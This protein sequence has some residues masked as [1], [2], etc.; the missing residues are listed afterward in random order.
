MRLTGAVV[1]VVRIST[2]ARRFGVGVDEEEFADRRLGEY[3]HSKV[4]LTLRRS[5][6]E[7]VDV[8][9]W[10]PSETSFL[11]ESLARVVDDSL[12]PLPEFSLE[13]G[14]AC[15]LCTSRSGSSEKAIQVD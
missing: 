6:I 8:K 12:Q 7:L 14:R 3:N 13:I 4:G 11:V 5:T 15:F 2:F 9:H 1:V 10:P